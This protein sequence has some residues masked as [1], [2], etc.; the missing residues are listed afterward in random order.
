MRLRLKLPRLHALMAA[1]P[2]SQNHLAIRIGLSRGHWSDIVNGKHLYVSAK[3]RTR[4]L[5]VFAVGPDELFE[6]ESGASAWA[7]TD[8]RRAITDRYMIDA[9][10]GQGGMG[11]VYL[12]RDLRHGRLV[13]LKVVAAEAVSGIG[14]TQFQREIATVAHLTHPSILPL[15]DS[16][17]ASGQPF[18]TMPWV[19][20]G[21]LRRRLAERGRL[22][23]AEALPLIRGIAAALTHAHAERVLHCDVKPEN[24]LLF[25]DHAWV[26]DFGIA[27]RLHG[28]PRQWEAR[29][30][31]DVSAGT[32][33]YVSPEQASGE[34]DLDGRSDVYSFGC[35]VYEMLAG[36]P[37]F[38]G[39]TTQAVVASRFMVPPAPL[40]DHAPGVPV[41]VQ[42]VV[43]RAME[44]KRERRPATPD[45]FAEELEA[46][47]R[48]A[49]RVIAAV[50]IGVARGAR[51]LAPRLAALAHPEN[52]TGAVTTFGALFQN[53]RNDLGWAWRQMRRHPGFAALEVGTFALA[54]G[55][56]AAVF[57]A[58]D[59]ALL[60]PLPFAASERLVN[61]RSADS[62]GTAIDPVSSDNWHDWDTQNRTFDGIALYQSQRLPMF[63]GGSAASVSGAMVTPNYAP[64]LGQR[65]AAGRVFT[66]D[67]DGVAEPEVMIAEGLW[68]RA[69]GGAATDTLTLMVNGY[70]RRVV[71]VVADGQDFPAGAELY[72]PLRY[73]HQ[74]GAG[75]NNINWTAVGRLR[76]G[77]SV[78]QARADLDRVSRGIRESDPAALYAWSVPVRPLRE[79]LV[80]SATTY[81]WLLMGAVAVVLLIACTNL[82]SA[83]LARG[84]DREREMAVR[85]A[86]GGGAQ[87]LGQMLLVERLSAALVGGVAG[88][89]LA[90]AL[91]GLLRYAGSRQLPRAAEMHVDARV[92]LFALV[93]ATLAGLLTGLLPARRGMK[94]GLAGSMSAGRGTARGWRGTPGRLLVGLE[95]AMAVTLVAAAGL[96]VQSFRTVLAR[97]LGFDPHGVITAEITLGGP[98]EREPARIATFWADLLRTVRSD[99]RLASSGLANWVPLG[100]GGTTFVEIAGKDLP[101]AG[102]GYR[103]VGDGYLEALGVPLLKG[104]MLAPGDIAGAPRVA[105]INQAMADKYWKDEEPVGRQVKAPSM[106]AIG[107]PAEWITV[108]GVVGNVRHWGFLEA[109]APEMYTSWPQVPFWGRSLT[110]VARGPDGTAVTTQSV[111]EAVRRVDP[112]VAANIEALQL[113]ADRDVGERRFTMQV[114]VAFGLLAL[115]LAAA[116]VYGVLS[117]AVATR[118]RE[119]AVRA[120]L[121]ADRRQLLG[122]VLRDA[123]AIVLA[124]AAGG[125]VITLLGARLLESLLVD[126][127]PRDPAVLSATVAVIV[128]AGTLAAL[129][130]AFRATRADP[131]VTLQAE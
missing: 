41:G 113:R 106:E 43:E 122:L 131:A 88:L 31:L 98:Y 21:S 74:G 105:V 127:S 61:L 75:R 120:A 109:P 111:R 7:D 44:L 34:T 95:I 114:I 29:S 24:V 58:V 76:P 51:R 22:D 17:V 107:H 65:L 73:R 99:G 13:A 77:I 126:I 27:R 123:L 79:M 20:G 64:V 68:R 100:T 129:R 81:L 130:P 45:A 84:I 78:T 5:E 12:A 56:T 91:V 101:G 55:L 82:A 3:T 26:T 125:L 42:A 85:A 112:T 97:P 19:R 60:R 124:G 49:S 25:G 50:T 48:G 9:E 66:A 93:V 47:N 46:A 33:A 121:G 87:R 96:L 36:R 70:R 53:L 108:V 2:L 28:E 14:L 62:L 38:E 94:A 67:Q 59:V 40:S 80:G 71:G 102:A 72:L 11:A 104:R 10:I 103:A 23:V 4:M 83:N 32:P 90:S 57:T 92:A 117:L 1:S 8:F 15:H 118:Q 37:P 115:A 35:M 86:I 52:R 39:S 54:I 128:V 89:G 116:G 119:L 69:L 30:E 63:A 110:L 16:G 6:I 18:F